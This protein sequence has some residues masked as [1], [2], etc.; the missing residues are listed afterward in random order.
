MTIHDNRVAFLDMDGVMIHV[1]STRRHCNNPTKYPTEVDKNCVDVLLRLQQQH[2]FKIVLSSSMRKIYKTKEEFLETYAGSGLEQ[3]VFHEDWKTPHY[4]NKIYEGTEQSLQDWTRRMSKPCEVDQTQ[5]W[6]G[7]EIMAWLEAHPDVNQ[8]VVF[9]DS[10]DMYPLADEQVVWVRHGLQ[11]GGLRGYREDWLVSHMALNF[12]D[13]EDALKI[14]AEKG[15][16][17][18]ERLE[19]NGLLDNQWKYHY[20]HSEQLVK[21]LRESE[22]DDLDDETIR[23]LRTEVIRSPILAMFLCGMYGVKIEL[24][25]MS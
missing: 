8:F 20:E 22:P 6:R 5:Y 16:K 4:S 19:L 9:D 15:R 13:E 1:L 2:G 24:A 10:P 23:L 7:H 11:D 14:K 18:L 3:L 25:P 12:V 21:L 17:L